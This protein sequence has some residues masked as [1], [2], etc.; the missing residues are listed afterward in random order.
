MPPMTLL[1]LRHGQSAA[2]AGLATASP[3]DISLTVLGRRQAEEAA[4]RIDAVPA[5]LIVSPFSRAR[6]TAAPLLA[7][8]PGV[9]VETWPI[10]EFTYLDTRRCANTTAAERKPMVEAYWARADPTYVDGPGAESFAAFVARLQAFQQRIAALPPIGTVVAVGHGQFFRG[11][12]H[13]LACGFVATAASMRA[14]RAAE[15]ATPMHNGDIVDMAALPAAWRAADADT[16]DFDRAAALDFLGDKALLDE[17]L[18]A[19]G[20]SAG[21]QIASLRLATAAQDSAAM[22]RGLHRVLPTL[23]ILASTQL[24]EEG[25]SLRLAWHS[26]EPSAARDTRT[27]ALLR[28]LERLLAQVRGV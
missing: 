28:R 20:A 1:L 22:R 26:G 25:E 5:L 21:E 19:F 27:A 16:G 17:V 4:A 15:T 12:V 24:Q 10:E 14:Y 11:Y 18:A 2:N 7:R 9:P 8:Y 13:C 23:R 3:A 6:A